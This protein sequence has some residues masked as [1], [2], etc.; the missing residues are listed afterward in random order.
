VLLLAVGYSGRFLVEHFSAPG[1]T[2]AEAGFARDMSTHH[3]QAAEMAMIVYPKATLE[4]VRT[5][6]FNIATSQSTEI[7]IMQTWL[8]DWHLSPTSSR[9]QM[10]WMPNGVKELTPGGLM[11]GIASKAEVDQL[12]KATGKN[13]DILF[14][15]LMVRHHLGGLHM[16][17]AILKL[18]DRTDVRSLAEAMRIVQSGEV[19][20]MQELLQS[21]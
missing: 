4:E 5:I 16:V 6:A 3:A 14:C 15:Q 7:G 9:Q 1:E 20:R 11:P 17:D 12:R 18:T 8:S 10:A 2:S 21:S 13:A 19:T